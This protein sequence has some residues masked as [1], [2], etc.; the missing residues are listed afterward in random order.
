MS[1]SDIPYSQ[2]RIEPNPS[3]LRQINTI[4]DYLLYI[5]LHLQNLFRMKSA[6]R[7]QDDLGA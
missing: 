1:D 3:F 6:L 4:S 5:Y 2:V 7:I